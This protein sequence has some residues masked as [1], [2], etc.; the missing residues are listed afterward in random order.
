MGADG[1]AVIKLRTK[2]ATEKALAQALEERDA[3]IRALE[4]ANQALRMELTDATMEG[5]LLFGALRLARERAQR[6]RR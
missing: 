6:W 1:A 5:T 2:T 4:A 3:K